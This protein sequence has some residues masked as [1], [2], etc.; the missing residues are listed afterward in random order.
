MRTAGRGFRIGL[1]LALAL[2]VLV[3]VVHP[4]R[5][6]AKTL[7]LLPDMFPTSPIRPLTW[8]TPPPR[9]EEYN[10]DF[11]VGHIDS[12]VYLPASGG[13]HG[14]L[15]LLL[16]AVGFPRRDPTLVRFADGLSRAGAVVMI[17]Q[18]SNLQEGEIV[19]GEVDGLVQALAYLQARPEVDPERVGFLGFS[20]GG[21]VA[22]LA[23]EDERGREQVAFMNI[24]GAYYDGL[25]FGRAVVTHQIEVDGRIE[26]WEPSELTVWVF[27]KQVIASLPNERDRDILRRA[28]VEKEEAA[29]AELDDLSPT[30]RLALELREQLPRERVDEIIRALPPSSL[31]YF[32]AISPSSRIGRLKSRLYLM[33]DYSDSYI[34]YVESRKIAANAPGDTLQVYNE[35]DLFAHVTPD[36]P[37]EAP[38]FVR[39]VLKLYRHAWSFCL[40]FL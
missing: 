28:F 21:S 18:S 31:E 27:F 34:P 11:S 30:G 5:V 38:L 12:D 19:P 40:E 20:V 39:E 3:S 4:W 16:G 7:L 8:V 26:P 36:R 22:M 24:F 9:I 2:L 14:A 13:Q 33:H 29:L 1:F 15:I 10:Y 32:Q 6:A 25:D 17:P 37:L 23:A 35:F